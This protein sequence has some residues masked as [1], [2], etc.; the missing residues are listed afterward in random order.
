M[1]LFWGTHLQVRRVDGFSRMMAQKTETRARMCRFGVSLTLFPIYGVKSPKTPILNRCFQAK[2]AK[3]KNMHIIK[4]P[5]KFCTAIK[6]T[7]CPSWV[8]RTHTHNKSKMAAAAIL[9]K[10]KNRH[11]SAMV[12][13][14]ATK[15][16]M[17][18][19]FDP[20]DH[21]VSKIGLSSCTF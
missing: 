21:S 20:L 10:S 12:G 3:S 15:F 9:E 19:Q 14:I 6:T 11:I 7:K 17:L 5:A 16:G 4:T 2:L 1:P 8:V 18:T 13:P